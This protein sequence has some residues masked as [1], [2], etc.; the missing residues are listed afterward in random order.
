MVATISVMVLLVMVA[1]SMLG[2]STVELR[3]GSQGRAMMEARSNARMALMLAIGELQKHAGPD[4]R[5]TAEADIIGDS[6]FAG[7]SRHETKKHYVGVFTT[8]KWADR[9]DAGMRAYWKPYEQT[10]NEKAFLRWLIS[11]APEDVGNLE[12]AKSSIDSRDVEELIGE[13]TLGKAMA[14]DERLL[15]PKMKLYKDGL[16]R[17]GY[18]WGVIDE[19]VKANV[20]TAPSRGYTAILEDRTSRLN[21]MSQATVGVKHLDGFEQFESDGHE[22]ELNRVLSRG[23]MSLFR[24][25]VVSEEVAKERFHD[26][27]VVSRSVLA[28]VLRGGLRR[29]LSLPFELPD[30][31]AND[32]ASDWEY[33]LNDA[34]LLTDRPSNYTS[35]W[36]FNNSGDQESQFRH[37]RMDASNYSPYW[38]AKKMG[39]LFAYPGESS[40]SDRTGKRKYLRG[41]SWDLLR[42]HYR[43]YKREFE[44]LDKSHR[45][46]RGMKSPSNERTWLAQPYQPY[47]HRTDSYG[48]HPLSTTYVGES[49][50][51]GGGYASDSLWDPFW[52][53]DNA[54]QKGDRPWNNLSFRT[55]GMTPVLTKFG[56]VLSV[57]KEYSS[58][59]KSDILHVCIDAVGTLWNPYNVSVEAESVFTQMN[60]AGLLWSLERRRGS[61]V[62][63]WASEPGKPFGVD[64]AFPFKHIRIGVAHPLGGDSRPEKNLELQPGELRTFALD[65]P[66]P[67][68]YSYSKLYTEPGKFTNNWNG[69]YYLKHSSKWQLQA[70]DEIKFIFKADNTQRSSFET[71]LGYFET[72]TGGAYNPFDTKTSDEL[73]DQPE[74]SSVHITDSSKMVEQGKF[75]TS[76]T[77]IPTGAD[78]K[79][80]VAYIEFKR[81]ASDEA[82]YGMATAIDPRSIVNH[83]KAMNS[84]GGIP[85]TWMASI[86]KVAD[87]DLLQ[88][89][90]G[91]RNNGFWGSSHE[92]FGQSRVIYYDV[93]DAPLVSL[94]G[95]QS[96]QLAS[97]GWTNPYTIGSSFPHPTLATNEIV[98]SETEDGFENVIY[99]LSYLT[100]MELWDRYFLSGLYLEGDY[101]ENSGDA[102]LEEAEE[103]IRRYLNPSE[104]NPLANKRIV[105]SPDSLAKSEDQLVD[106][107]THYR[108]M[109]RNLM[110][111]GGFNVNSTRKEAWKAWLASMYKKDIPKLNPINGQVSVHS[112]SGTP[113]AR[114]SV[115]S[116]GEGE[117]WLGYVELT[118]TQIDQL[119]ESIVEQVRSRGPFLSVSD[120]VNRRISSDK[121]GEAGALEAAIEDALSSGLYGTGTERGITGRLRQS[122]VLASLGNVLVARSDTF[123]VR[124]Y[125]EAVNPSTGKI[126]A[127][128]W[129][130]ATVQRVPTPVGDNGSLLDR[131]NPEYKTTSD[132]AGEDPYVLNTDASE[133]AKIY[134]RQIK[135]VSFRWLNASEV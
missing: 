99:D 8:E 79:K 14:D 90:V 13:G 127:R 85:E 49:E 128:A 40:G 73:I 92:G 109:A 58:R 16:H 100:N 132:P 37:A 24:D 9:D 20:A 81:P 84:G 39:Y 50:T 57:Y 87:F 42:C 94:G 47:S 61:S 3:S 102:A 22:L 86:K 10:R 44:K 36:E 43:Q 45:A 72:L 15:V 55:Y 21:L 120:F 129:C 18:A 112:T 28:D 80:A 5:V 46:R 105:L 52:V 93:P 104:K 62:E 89:G 103:H 130:E 98:K 6:G 97:S 96:C 48:R 33:D 71:N 117:D 76:T 95:F 65:F 66:A 77:T 101:D 74:M 60:L 82:L 106:E 115:P 26:V 119:A 135:V 121:T 91:A 19:G 114:M 83:S 75:E 59:Y 108:W 23:Q 133:E 69:G 53:Y 68:A 12:F 31:K 11:G 64:R 27:S 34:D 111:N 67:K 7:W 113:F 116:G 29:D 51:S 88:N 125:G 122:D 134:G 4:Q 35:I 17:G 126:M 2:L 56:F 124:A 63:Q 110:L 78:N 25:G 30:L 54:A 32:S 1:L 70:G 118:E 123:V 41:P 107:L 38:W 131:L